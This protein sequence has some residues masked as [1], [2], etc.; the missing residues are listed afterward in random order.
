[1][2]APTPLPTVDI[3]LVIPFHDIDPMNIV[4]HGRY[5][6][7]LEIARCELL[8]SFEYGYEQMRE[9]GYVWPVVDIRI[10]YIK[11]L[12]FKQRIRINATLE[13]WEYRLKVRYTL[14]DADSGEKL[15]KAHT[16]QVAVDLETEEMTFDTHSM[17]KQKLGL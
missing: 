5:V 12:R 14:Y 17:L 9:S 8:E 15:T 4:W 3:E 11:P 10:K 1:M 6:K 2:S 13:E 7:Y 16:T